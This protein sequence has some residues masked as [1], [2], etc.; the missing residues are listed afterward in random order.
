M[1]IWIDKK[2][3]P[4]YQNT[5]NT[6]FCEQEGY[7]FAVVAFKKKYNIKEKA[8]AVKIDIFADTKYFLYINGQHIGN[9][10]VCSGGDYGNTKTMPVQYYST[11]EV[12]PTGDTLDI[13]VLVQLSPSVQTDV[14][15][16]RG[17]FWLDGEILYKDGSSQRIESD[18]TWECRLETQYK[19]VCDVDF[20]ETP[21]LWSKAE[22]CENVWNIKKSPIKNLVEKKINPVSIYQAESGVIYAEFDKIYAGYVSLNVK[23]QGFFEVLLST[24]EVY[25]KENCKHTIKGRDNIEYRSI[26]LNSIGLIKIE[27][28]EP[29]D[30][31]DIHIEYT[32]YPHLSEGGFF[33]NDEIL[34]K[35]FEVGKHT[36]EICRQTI[37]LDSPTH[38]EN[39]GCTGDYYISSLISY[40]C[41]GDTSLSKFD[42][43]RTAEYLRMTDGKMFHTS[44]SLIW[45]MMLYDNYMFS[46]NEDVLVKCKDVLGALLKRF[47]SYTGEHGVL[48]NAPNYMFID[49][50]YIDKYNLHHPPMALGQTVLNAFYYKALLTAKE[51]YSVLEMT[52]EALECQQKAESLKCSFNKCFLDKEKGMY[53]GGMNVKYVPSD[54]LPENTDTKYYLKHA[55][56]LAALYDL[57]DDG[58]EIIEKVIRDKTPIQPYFTHFLI[59]AI[60]HVGLFDKYGLKEIYKWK[61]LVD[62]CDKGMKEAWEIFTGYEYD[63]S[64]AW[65]A[66]PTYQLMSKISGLEIKAPGFKKI[67]LNPDLYGLKFANI[68][69]PTPYGTIEL[70]MNKEVTVKIP[71][72]IEAYHKGVRLSVGKN[73]LV[74]KA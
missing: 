15:C 40:F 14:S 26:H 16:G 25:E 10:P 62:E 49:W 45:V 20:N 28:V 66:T 56:I 1:F 73:V 74:E 51:I 17:G 8:K 41:F 68:K 54:W 7:E 44:Y 18:D 30:I 3:Y 71:D 72:G 64:H 31:V 61:D 13:Y 37:E 53:L 22:T 34:N 47:D 48:E 57:C 43:L 39:L 58:K 52:D 67:S 59:E 5:F 24:Q 6:T 21:D 50:I 42:I 60:Y 46:G 70:E 55:N 69:I 63:Y 4:Q 36:T 19:D 2:K 27:G 38:Q 29:E 11:Y 12:E 35:I 23:K 32:H 33:S 65:G 9:G